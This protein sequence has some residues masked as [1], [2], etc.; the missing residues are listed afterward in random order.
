[1]IGQ[2]IGAAIAAQFPWSIVGASDAAM[3][4]VEHATIA[5]DGDARAISGDVI[6]RLA[7]ADQPKEDR[8]RVVVNC[9]LHNLT[10]VRRAWTNKAG[11]ALPTPKD[12]QVYRIQPGTAAA[13]VQK[14]ACGPVD[15]LGIPK[16][17][18]PIM[19]KLR[20]VADQFFR[21]RN[22]GLRVEAA[23]ALAAVDP[24]RAS[25]SFEQLLD[26]M[27][28]IDQQLLVRALKT[29]DSPAPK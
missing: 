2:A 23:E 25:A 13:L 17:A 14:A 21:L 20:T 3:V 19:L 28:P 10:Y 18:I 8:F 22:L 7:K 12:A 26:V 6:V 15:S 9:R 24:Q 5:Q 4:F 27:V 1:V 16:S 11:L 29:S